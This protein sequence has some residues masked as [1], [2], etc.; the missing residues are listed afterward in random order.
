V[1]VPRKKMWNAILED[2]IAKKTDEFI[3]DSI[4]PDLVLEVIN[5]NS[6]KN[7]YDLYSTKFRGEI[8]YIEEFVQRVVG[9]MAKEAVQ[10][11]ISGIAGE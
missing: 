2:Y 10:E 6:K 11:T 4:V 3:E 7:T 5:E 9:K 1:V 8:Q